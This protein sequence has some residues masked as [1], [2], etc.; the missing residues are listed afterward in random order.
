M[1]SNI[2]IT[3]DSPLPTPPAL[4]VVADYQPL[5]TIPTSII[6]LLRITSNTSWWT[7]ADKRDSNATVLP[8]EIEMRQ[9]AFYTIVKERKFY[10][11]IAFW[12][13]VY[14]DPWGKLWSKAWMLRDNGSKVVPILRMSLP[15]SYNNTT[16][17]MKICWT[18]VLWAVISC[19]LLILY[20]ITSY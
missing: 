5:P 3:F 12:F 1:N 2:C 6:K 9:Q 20:G 7:R 15:K 18:V 8:H 17:T 10:D 16:W 4:L 11:C 19:S 14:D 13:R